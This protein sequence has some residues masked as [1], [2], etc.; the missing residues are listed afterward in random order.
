MLSCCKKNEPVPVLSDYEKINTWIEDNMMFYYLWND[1][2]DPNGIRKDED[3]E[4]YFKQLIVSDDNYS[5]V[6]NDFK[7]L[8]MNLSGGGG[9]GYSYFLYFTDDAVVGK[10]T[11]VAKQ[12][13]AD[14]AGLKRGTIFTKINGTS[15]SKHNYRDLT[16]QMLNKHTLTV[17]NDGDTETDYNIQIANF[18]EN[19][20][21]L[22]TVYDFD[23]RRIAY[24]VYN[25][26]V[27]DNG[28]LSQEYDI[29]LNNVFGRFK[30]ENI[31]ELIL[32]LR[33]NTKG[34]I[35]SSMILA[36]LITHNPDTKEIYARYHYNKS[37]Q[38]TVKNE[39]GDDYLNLY[40]TNTVNNEP[41]NSVGDKLDRV[42]ILTSPETGV[43][44]EILVNSLRLS[45]N[46]VVV[47][48]RTEGRNMFS[49]FLY[50]H[51][52]EKQRINTWAIVPVV[53]Q[54]SNKTGNKDIALIPDVE[55]TESLYDSTPL[56]DVR[57]KTLAAALQII[58]PPL[59][60]TE[61]NERESIIPQQTTVNYL[62]SLSI[63]SI[64][65]K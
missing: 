47:G 25:A 62:H 3:P 28:D 23:G 46:V 59:L 54:V 45:T 31:N 1:L 33:Y 2:I 42:F 55:I 22:D 13:P 64:P 16:V 53:I 19:P 15:L 41:L 43:M 61:S 17:R 29:R 4:Q 48:N 26:F 9:N 21:F 27:P 30:D 6:T 20:V 10:I 40:Y 44:G 49:I 37:L 14:V 8:L 50:E 52:P 51:D 18:A 35:L 12:S 24:L 65:S 34:N 38:Q 36:S 60:S 11:Y 5:L 57:E 56:G 39:L 63:N 7:S 32:D 58:S